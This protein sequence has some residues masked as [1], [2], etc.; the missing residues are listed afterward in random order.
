MNELEHKSNGW[1][2]IASQFRFNRQ[3]KLLVTTIKQM[4]YCT[5]LFDENWNY[6]TFKSQLLFHQVAKRLGL[7]Y[8]ELVEMDIEEIIEWLKKG[9]KVDQEFRRIIAGRIKDN[10]WIMERGKVRILSGKEL[11][12]YRK[13]ENKEVK[14]DKHKKELQGQP[15]SVG[16]VKGKV[17]LVYGVSDL[18][19][20]KKGNVMVAKSTVPSFVPAME[21][22]GA[23]LTEIGGLLSHAAIVSREL[24]TPCIVGVENVMQILKDGDLVEVDAN[25]GVI[26]KLS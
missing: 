25:K 17:V 6:L 7:E 2:T 24:S 1:R 20:V 9:V 22:A 8:T 4:A 10:A 26:R 3:D 18:N 14:I 12:R 15:A 21:R 19:K 16:Q 23:I 5:N 13:I 11:E